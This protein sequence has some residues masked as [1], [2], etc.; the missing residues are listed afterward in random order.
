MIAKLIVWDESRYL[1][2]ARMQKA[3]A[4]C[5]VVGV[6]TNIG[7]LSRLVACPAFAGA[8]LDTGLIERQREFL[9][10]EA[11][12]PATEVFLVATLAELLSERDP[13]S[14]A[15]GLAHD[16]F[17]PWAARDGWRMNL[18]AR[19]T[20]SWRIG[21]GREGAEAAR[22]DVGIAY[23]ATRGRCPARARR[24][25]PAR[26]GTPTAA[27]RSNS[28]TAACRQRGR[29]RRAPAAAPP[30]L[31]VRRLPRDRA[32]RPLHSVEAGGQHGGGLTAPMPGKV[33]AL[34]AQPGQTVEKGAPLLILEAMK[35]E[36]TI[37][38]PAAGKV[39]G[40]RYSAGDQVADGEDLL[41]FEPQ[42]RKPQGLAPRTAEV[43]LAAGEFG[44]PLL[45]KRPRAFLLVMRGKQRGKE[46]GF[47]PAGVIDRHVEAMVDRFDRCS[48]GL[49]RLATISAARSAP[50]RANGRLHH[51]I[52]QTHGGRL[53]GVDHPS[54]EDQLERAPLA[55]QPG[56]ALGAAIAG[57]DAQFHLRLAEACLL[58]G[59]ADMARHGDLA[60]AAQS[61]SIDGRDDRLG[62]PLDEFMI[63]WPRRAI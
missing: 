7:F 47:Q 1:A 48:D 34:L 5:R 52:D 33:V 3:L 30:C 58:R 2:L 63:S 9:F 59:K 11:K 12:A 38:A 53:G 41:D 26:A 8:D 18:A 37:T 20:V 15:S 35:M 24:C 40:F 36:H 60:A 57:D 16:L 45:Q 32:R 44:L 39:K 4:D 29:H 10:P 54:A 23:G 28:T 62:K 55:Y 49:R 13:S 17:S 51:A 6:T 21:A 43:G 27:S 42:G 61:K 50:H 25:S 14:A 19:R 31:P 22:I 46:T 56:Q